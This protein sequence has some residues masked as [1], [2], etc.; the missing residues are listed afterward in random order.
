MIL[1]KIIITAVLATFVLAVMPT[2]QAAN[3]QTSA[4]IIYLDPACSGISVTGTGTYQPGIGRSDFML[5]DMTKDPFHNYVDSKNFYYS[6][7]LPKQ[8][9]ESWGST[10]SLTP[11]TPYR[12]AFHIWDRTGLYVEAFAVQDFT[13][14]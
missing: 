1:I 5:I 8:V 9:T 14:K 13:C 7:P 4:A 10:V 12:V 2:V 3:L 6:P 11:G